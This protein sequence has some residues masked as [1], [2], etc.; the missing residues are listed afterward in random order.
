[1][2]TY[3]Q[4]KSDSEEKTLTCRYWV[5]TALVEILLHNSLQFTLRPFVSNSTLPTLTGLSSLSL[6]LLF[7]NYYFKEGLHR[8]SG[9]DQAPYLDTLAVLRKGRST[10]DSLYTIITKG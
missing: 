9:I 10:C 7:T 6:Y 2:E 4:V 3:K 5:S 1:M 8:L